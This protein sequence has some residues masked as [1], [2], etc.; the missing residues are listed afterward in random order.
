MAFRKIEPVKERSRTANCFY[1]GMTGG[2]FCLGL[3]RERASQSSALGIE[4]AVEFGERLQYSPAERV[5]NPARSLLCHL[6]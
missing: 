5:N 4:R 6:Q 2:F 3:A 1:Q